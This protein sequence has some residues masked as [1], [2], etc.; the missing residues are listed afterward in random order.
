MIEGRGGEGSQSDEPSYYL[1]RKLTV[2]MAVSGA[3]TR[4]MSCSIRSS[5]QVP[6]QR[7]TVRRIDTESDIHTDADRSKVHPTVVMGRGIGWG[8]VHSTGIC[9]PI[10]V[11]FMSR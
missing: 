6:S 10:P 3:C 4:A 7:Q 2:R 9:P 11:R 5:C 8:L 1:T